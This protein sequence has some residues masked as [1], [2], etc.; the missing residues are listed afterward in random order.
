M[1]DDICVRIKENR[2]RMG[3]T[4]AQLGTALG[5]QKSAIQKY[6][7][8]NNHYKLETIIKLSQVFG[9]SVS[10]LIG[11]PPQEIDEIHLMYGK[12]GAIGIELVDV[13]EKLNEPGRVKVVTYAWDILGKYSSQTITNQNGDE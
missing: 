13:F 10:A 11:E 8:G 6:E 3:L 5:V 2:K 9:I 12:F 7:S 1:Y 4:Q